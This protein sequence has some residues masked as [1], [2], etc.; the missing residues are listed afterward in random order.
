MLTNMADDVAQTML[1]Q[2]M[3]V[4]VN[5]ILAPEYGNPSWALAQMFDFFNDNNQPDLAAKVSDL[6]KK[7]YISDV[8]H[9]RASFTFDHRQPYFFSG[10]IQSS[11]FNS[12][13]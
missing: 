9:N 5:D 6:V 10:R 8:I 4:G 3:N 1:K 2:Y 13:C 7:Y 12:S 11:K